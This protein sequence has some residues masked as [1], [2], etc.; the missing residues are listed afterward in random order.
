MLRG[1]WNCLKVGKLINWLKES[2]KVL[3][4]EDIK[5][6]ARGGPIETNTQLIVNL[7]FYH[8]NM[9]LQ[10]SLLQWYRALFIALEA[11][12]F[13]FAYF[14]I[15]N[16]YLGWAWFPFVLGILGCF[17]WM[18]VCTQRTNFVDKQR[19][20]IEKL[21]KDS[22]LSRC[23]DVYA[24]KKGRWL[25]QNIFNV[26]FPAVVIFLWFLLLLTQ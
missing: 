5:Q 13:T 24:G 22:A 14:L 15:Q 17:A 12:L 21:V 2:G 16:Q 19:D 20:E 7:Q 25:A 4:G 26:V 8:D 10:E 1:S 23:W 18:I 3:V 11:A 9:V 6:M